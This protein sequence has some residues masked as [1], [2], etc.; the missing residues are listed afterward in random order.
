V[1]LR[2]NLREGELVLGNDALDLKELVFKDIVVPWYSILGV[3]YNNLLWFFVRSGY[4]L[5]L[6]HL[7]EI[8][9]LI[10]FT[11]GIFCKKCWLWEQQFSLVGFSLVL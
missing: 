7:K 3:T 6:N 9:F 10:L 5:F 11:L 2:V 8:L 4:L 1:R